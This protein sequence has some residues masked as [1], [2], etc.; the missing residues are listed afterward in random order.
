MCLAYGNH[1]INI[2]WLTKL[3]NESYGA[4]PT[5]KETLNLGKMHPPSQHHTNR[6]LGC[7]AVTG[8]QFEL[9]IGVGERLVP[10]GRQLSTK[11]SGVRLKLKIR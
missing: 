11:C 9:G 3:V 7:K 1:S 10:G 4:S 2:G 6:S 8:V 5:M